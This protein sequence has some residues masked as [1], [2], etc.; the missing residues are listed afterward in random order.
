M[1]ATHTPGQVV[2]TEDQSALGV[3]YALLTD[4]AAAFPQTLAKVDLPTDLQKFRKVYPDVL[5]VFEAARVA[6]GEAMQRA[7]RRTRS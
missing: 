1:S 4:A 5:P 2:L 3:L 6:G 7:C